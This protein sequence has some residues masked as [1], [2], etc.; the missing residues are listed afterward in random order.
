MTRVVRSVLTIT[1]GAF[2]FVAGG[3]AVG[4]QTPRPFP[5]PTPRPTAVAPARASTPPL[6]VRV[7]VA[8]AGGFDV[9]SI[10]LETY[11]A[12]VLGGEA[13]PN[14]APAALQALAIA[15]RTYAMVNRDRHE[16][17]GG[18]DVCDQVHCQVVRTANAA[19]EAAAA[20]TAGQILLRP[21]GTPARVFYSASC[22][23]RTEIPSEVW[24]GEEDPPYMP[25]QVDEAC[26]GEPVWSTDMSRADLERVLTGAG[27]RGALRDVRISSRNGSGRVARLDLAGMTPT[28]ISAQDLRMAVSRVFGP[29]YL[30]SAAFELRR[31]GDQY[32][33]SGHGYGHGV[34]M[35][36]FGAMN[37]ARQ[38]ARADA[39]LLRYFPGLALGPASGAPAPTLTKAPSAPVP[40]PT[41]A[42][43]A[44]PT[45]ANLAVVLPPRE[46]VARDEVTAVVA[47]ARDEAAAWLGIPS[48]S[49][50]NIRIHASAADF[51]EATGKQWFIPGAVVSGV[52]HLPPIDVLRNRG[53]LD[54]TVKHALVHRLAD[55]ALATRRAWVR[56]GLAAYASEPG[57][58]ARP[59]NTPGRVVCPTDIELLQPL[60]AG[61]YAEASA[62]ARACVVRQ[63]AGG[64]D[65]RDVR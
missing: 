20:A 34:G 33:F 40:T 39:I 47:K 13:A 7:G 42:P 59:P 54:R 38:G 53:I 15:V 22:G 57:A 16:S 11:V 3:S 35:C 5:A 30:M 9:V 4:T 46:T 60:S 24:P 29:R 56:E 31:T 28:S 43:S 51:M 45:A 61:A 36:V 6:S 19:T 48:P 63:L 26:E 18:F 21:D 52:V 12:R 2:A 8:R 44:A 14:T 10:P 62:R 1:L 41:T 58:V 17:G 27:F 23:G 25:S 65:W 64:R 32:N 37:L 55:D 50:L 49:S